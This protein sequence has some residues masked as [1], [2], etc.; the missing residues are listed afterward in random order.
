MQTSFE[1]EYEVAELIKNRRSI[2]SFAPEEI[3]ES[4]IATLFEATRWAPSST[5]EQPWRYI[6]ATKGQ[7]LFDTILASL[8]EGNRVWAQHAPLLVVSLARKHFTRFSGEN[9]YALYD[10]G[11]ANAL[12]ALQAVDLGLQVRQMAG[13]HHDQ[14]RSALHVPDAYHLG[15]V[16]AIGYPGSPDSLPENLRVREQAPRERYRQ[17]EF[18]M[19]KT[20]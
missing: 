7:P 4:K 18:V 5:N 14:L 12:L 2:R 11:G 16:M 9:A 3:E 15:V 17:A 19:N 10:L 8:N 20:F 13:F 1:L 6:F